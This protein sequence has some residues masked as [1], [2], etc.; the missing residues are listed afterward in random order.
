MKSITTIENF[1][2]E[3]S[4]IV[5]LNSD[6]I[7]PYLRNE[8]R[9]TNLKLYLEKMKEKK[10]KVLFLGEAPGH[11]GSLK[12]GIPFTSENIIKN[13]EYFKENIGKSFKVENNDNP[14]SENSA[15]Y[16]WESLRENKLTPLIWNIFPFHPFEKGKQYSNRTPNSEEINFGFDLLKTLL[17]LFNIEKVVT[18]GRKADSK[19]KE[20]AEIIKMDSNKKKDNILYVRHPARNGHNDFMQTIKNLNDQKWFE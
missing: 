4:Q 13:N 12:T 1:V 14:E 19:R 11:R 2:Q 20:I 15:K 8:I 6:T 10:P 18:V 7:N 3:I 17:E 5:P 16:V 9:Q